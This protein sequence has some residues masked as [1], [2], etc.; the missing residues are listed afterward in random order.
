MGMNFAVEYE[1]LMAMTGKANIFWHIDVSKKP[2][3]VSPVPKK[4]IKN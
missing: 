4:L 3:P 2:S 1:I